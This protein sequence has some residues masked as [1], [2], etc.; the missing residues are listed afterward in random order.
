MCGLL[1]APFTEQELLVSLC[2]L[3]KGSCPGVHG[4]ALAFFLKHWETL[5]LGLCN[6]FQEAMQIGEMHVAFAKGL[7]FLISKEGGNSKE[8]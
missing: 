2:S 5:A 8:I 1:L 4:L 6:P 3:D 7:I